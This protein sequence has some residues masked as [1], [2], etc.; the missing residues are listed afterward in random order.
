MSAV[1]TKNFI[2]LISALLGV[3]MLFYFIPTSVY[4]EVIDAAKNAGASKV[5]IMEEP[6]ASAIGAGL[7]INEPKGKMIVD[8]GG[9]TSEVAVIS[10]GKIVS[11]MSSGAMSLPMGMSGTTTFSKSSSIQPVCVGPGAMQLTVM[12]YCATSRAILR[13]SASSVALLAP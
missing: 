12:P 5:V 11:A 13:V 3:I 10:L 2:K 1:K 8:I 7:D 9:G 4:A 6:K